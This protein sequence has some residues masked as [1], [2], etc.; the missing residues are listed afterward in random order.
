MDRY[1]GRHL[2]SGIAAH[3]RLGDTGSTSDKKYRTI[4]NHALEKFREEQSGSND[5]RSMNAEFKRF[6]ISQMKTFMLADHDTTSST[7]CFIF[8]LL[9]RN[10][11]ALQRVRAKHDEVFGT[12]FTQAF[13][14]LTKNPLSLNKLPF[15]LA[16]I[17]ESL[18]L[19]PPSSTTRDGERGFS[20]NQND[21][22]YPTEGITV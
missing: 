2:E 19:F 5:P 17:K 9:S 3:Q 7:L 6:A 14:K 21:S 18:R 10:P 8:Y 22:Q 15:T 4:M 13:V 12:N 11:S 1:V 20:L 16:I